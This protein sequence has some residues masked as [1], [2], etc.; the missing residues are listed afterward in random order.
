MV[1]WM[2]NGKTSVPVASSDFLQAIR[3]VYSK[4]VLRSQCRFWD[5]PS[6]IRNREIEPG[7]VESDKVKVTKA[8]CSDEPIKREG[9][10]TPLKC[11]PS[12]S[13]FE[14]N[15]LLLFCTTCVPLLLLLP[16]LRACFFLTGATA[17]SGVP[18]RAR[19]VPCHVRLYH[20]G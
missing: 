3:E 13:S 6:S 7:T 16:R 10:M 2:G 5:C 17:A 15:S 8:R 1:R 4:Y 19:G 18:A 20:T 11:I 9:D 12:P 14:C